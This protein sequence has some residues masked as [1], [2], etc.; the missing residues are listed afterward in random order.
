M[1]FLK[2]LGCKII[3]WNANILAECGE[4]SQCMFRKLL[5]AIFIVSTLWGAIGYVF[6]GRYIGIESWY[7]K[8][9][10]AA[11]FILIVVCIERVIIL[12][13][14]KHKFTSII[15][16]FLAICMS[17]LGAFIFDQVIF[18][19]DLNAQIRRQ[20]EE[21]TIPKITQTRMLTLQST[22]DN[23]SAQIDSLGNVNE[24]LYEE[25]KT[26]PIIKATTLQTEEKLTGEIDSLG[27]PIKTKIR[28][29]AEY[30][31]EN[32]K[33]ALVKANTDQINL[34]QEELT[35]YQ[36]A[37]QELAEDVR[38]EYLNP[39]Y[40]NY[41]KI[42]FMEELNAT[43]S[44]ITQSWI[45]IVFYCL[46]FAFMLLLELF[47]VSIKLGETCDYE[48]IVEHQLH[49]KIIELQNAERISTENLISRQT[50]KK[51]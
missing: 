44:V 14:G 10:M 28:S 50:E 24:M 37:K 47:V 19:N 41:V 30:I 45:T 2:K 31:T 15:R 40:P 4:S 48:K 23:Y 22:I 33:M 32:P 1:S 11:V 12:K 6:A 13:V 35:K 39:N 20:R 8:T 38:Q 7:G 36:Q 42:G 9:I 29:T 43:L 26:R 25:I 18:K 27:N 16:I 3:G 5:S 21:V 34:Y 51:E 49:V 17:T 46:L